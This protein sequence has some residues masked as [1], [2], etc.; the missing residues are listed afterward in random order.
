MSEIIGMQANRKGV[1]FDI[2]RAGKPTEPAD[3]SRKEDRRIDQ[4]KLLE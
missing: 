2:L 3:I 4:M 1:G